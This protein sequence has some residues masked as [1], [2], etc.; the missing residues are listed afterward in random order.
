MGYGRRLGALAVALASVAPVVAFAQSG[1]AVFR[2][3]RQTVW[4]QFRHG[5][6]LNDVVA[7]PELPAR[8]SWR[9][10]QP[11]KGTSTSP[12]VAGR[13][14]LVAA[15][16]R[17]VYAIDGA[18]GKP[19]W[20]WDGDNEVMS[21][22]V[23]RDG[24]AIVG[25]GDSDSPVWSPPDYAVVGMGP[26]DLDGIDLRS[27]ETRWKFALTGTGMPMPAL[28]GDGLL[29]VDGSGVLLALDART[30]AYR[31]RRFFYSN[32]SMA[33]ILIARDGTAYFGGGFPGAVYAVRSSDGL[34]VW[35][36]RF[37]RGAGSFDDCPLATDGSRIFGMYST[38][39]AGGPHAFVAAGVRARQHVYALDAAT[40][41]P[42]WDTAL[43][44]TGVVPAY[45]ESAIPMY[46]G[47]TVFDG[48][49]IAPIVSALDARTGRVRWSLRVG[50]PVKGGFVLHDGK[51]YFGD[52][53]GRLWAVDPV[54]G[55]VLGSVQTDLR[56]NV[57]SP[58][59][60][61]GSLVVGSSGGPVIAVPLDAIASSRPV[62]GVT[63]RPISFA[64]LWAGVLALLAAAVAAVLLYRQRAAQAA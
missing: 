24:V 34:P 33:S 31:W 16:D 20:Q 54:T 28:A 43:A 44:V 58:I 39:L 59:A 22:P 32:A 40:G 55:R 4:D 49:A 15:N 57:G 30:G 29:H 45:N 48:S 10:T 46:A 12:V 1:S 53:G 50:G 35:T 26:S 61:N 13:L 64:R 25:T 3:D 7:N 60:L 18:D 52:L 23:Y 6:G 63:T 17:A 14:V 42:R 37:A 56:F 8:P 38:P 19:V 11:R 2:A 36:H 5:G 47:G 21:A 51:L 9:F 41:K 62:P 27:G